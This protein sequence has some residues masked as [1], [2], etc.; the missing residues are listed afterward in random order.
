MV[1]PIWVNGE[2][3]DPDTAVVSVFDH[4]L[5]VGDGVFETVKAVHG[6]PFALTRHLDRLAL[7]A[8][9][10]G[11]PEPDLGA[12]ADGVRQCLERDRKSTRLNSSHVKISYAVFCLK[13]KKLGTRGVRIG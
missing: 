9:R 7:S 13:K 1:L 6:Q 10:M 12:I 8:K 3:R 4:G 5:M 2:L 11:L